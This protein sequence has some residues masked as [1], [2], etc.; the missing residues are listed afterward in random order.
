[1]RRILASRTFLL[2]SILLLSSFQIEKNQPVTIYMIGDS[3]MANKVAER[4]PETGWG[5]VFGQ[6]FSDKVKVENHAVNGRSSKSFL[7]EGLW[8]KVCQQLNPGDYVFIQFGH[9][10]QK[11]D[12]PDR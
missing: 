2:A 4:F 3:T 5:Q 6:F 11:V 10:D 9:N 12:S 8:D 7:D 1:M